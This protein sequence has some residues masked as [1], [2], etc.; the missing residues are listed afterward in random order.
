M[1]IF[2]ISHHPFNAE[3]YNLSDID[4]LPQS[5]KR[6]GLL[7]PLVLNTNHQVISGNRR[8]KALLTLGIKDVPVVI[9]DIP[10]TDVHLYIISHNS[11][12]VKTSRELLNEIK[13]LSQHISK[14]QG[15]RSDLTSG[16]IDGSC[17]T[18]KVISSK[19]GISQGNISK[20]KFIDSHNP[21]MVN[22][23][24]E[25]HLTINQAFK[26]TKRQ[27]SII[28]IKDESVDSIPETISGKYTI[29]NKSSVDMSELSDGS[30]DMIMTSPPYWS[31]RNYGNPEQLGLEESINQY[32]SNL[33]DVFNESRRVLNDSG[34]L[35]VV[36][37][38]KYV[39]ACLSSIPHIFALEMMNQGWVQRNCIIWRKT[40]PKPESVKNRLQSSYEFIFFFTKSDKYYFDDDSIRQP[41][42]YS[43]FQD[44]RTPHHHSLK[45]D[46]QSHSPV[47]QNPIGKIP[48]DVVETSKHSYGVGK[49]LGL[50]IEHGAVYPPEIC[51]N[52]IK[53]SS[54]LGGVV[55]DPFSG[56]GTTGEVAISLG[57]K[58]IG[59]E[60]NSKFVDLSHIRLSNIIL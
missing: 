24:D 17:D 45:G 16:N 48:S 6:V 14:G 10:D 7:E 47:F 25:G 9:R 36:I 5:I 46:V 53:S 43:Q 60:I 33:M 1:N 4:T 30:V 26:E 18:R 55:L 54:P 41:Y 51:I 37:G 32:I 57:R 49:K 29:Y 2:D 58:Y 31:Q 27:V 8:L 28:K 42:K 39:N 52:P 50:D 20:L 34:S 35:Y 3:I 19:L 22:L 38:D 21:E 15:F 44:I 12:R 11:Q 59:Y 23:I 56:S 40:N 13:Y